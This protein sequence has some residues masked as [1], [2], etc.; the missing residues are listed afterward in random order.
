[1]CLCVSAYVCV[2]ERGVNWGPVVCENFPHSN[3]RSDTY[4]LQELRGICLLDFT[5]SE[6]IFKNVFFVFF[7]CKR[8]NTIPKLFSL[9]T[10]FLFSFKSIVQRHK[11]YHL[12]TI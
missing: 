12:K 5:R 1:M 10:S 7:F 6:M 4:R 3:P 9:P 8:I 11:N 2:E